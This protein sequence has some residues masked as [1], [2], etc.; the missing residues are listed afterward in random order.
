MSNPQYPRR[1]RRLGRIFD[2]SP[3]YFLTIC[4]DNRSRVL[5]NE[6][7]FR[8]I[9]SFCNN[10]MD[11]YGVFVDCHVLMPDHVHLIITIAPNSGTTPGAWVK[12]F[13]AVVANRAFK[14]Q[15]GFFDHVLRSDE[16]R[17]EKWE[18]IRM[19]SVRAGLVKQPDNWPFAQRFNP[20][21]GS[22]M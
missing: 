1:Q 9:Q 21:D 3:V 17:S 10:S 8:R 12:A 13:K 19:N 2:Q 7:V 4:T 5:A 20:F 22:G 6:G 16:S 15:S 14:W 18:Y 11:H